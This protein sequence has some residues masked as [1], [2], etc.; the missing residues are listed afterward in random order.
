MRTKKLAI[1]AGTSLLLGA[2]AFAQAPAALPATNTAAAPVNSPAQMPPECA[3]WVQAVKPPAVT[4]LKDVKR[5][6]VDS[7][8]DDPIA[9]Q[10]QA[11]VVAELM[12]SDKFVVTENRAKADAFLKGTGLEK[13]SIETHSYESGTAAGAS[14][15]GFHRSGDFASG[16]FHSSG[17]AINDASSSSQAVNDARASVRLVNQDGDVLWATAQESKGAKYKGASA[18]VA[19]KI[20]KQLMRDIEKLEKKTEAESTRPTAGK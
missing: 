19:D 6:F 8:G 5:I 13:T 14:G 12:K 1:A 7:F 10:I 15:G 3:A 16:G 18:D 4:S 17:A 2:C 20:V 9:Q 11:M